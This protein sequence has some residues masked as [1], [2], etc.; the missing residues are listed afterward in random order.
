MTALYPVSIATHG[1]G[2]NFTVQ[3]YMNSLDF[4]LTAGEKA[5]P[6]LEIMGDLLVEAFEELKAAALPAAEKPNGAA[7]EE[8]KPAPKKVAAKKTAAKKPTAKKV[9][10]KPTAKKPAKQAAQAKG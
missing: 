2:L 1:V 7:A 5:V 4:G 3:S 10:K 6:D 8:K 9:A